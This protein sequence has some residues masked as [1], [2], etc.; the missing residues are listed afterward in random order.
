MLPFVFTR[1]CGFCRLCYLGL[2]DCVAVSYFLLRVCRLGVDADLVGCAV[3]DFVGVLVL[4]GYH[5]TFANFGFCCGNIL[6]LVCVF[7]LGLS[8]WWVWIVVV[9]EP[10]VGGWCWYF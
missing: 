7:L 3:L 6:G 10:V 2:L 5:N 9:F 8:C 1:L 4:C